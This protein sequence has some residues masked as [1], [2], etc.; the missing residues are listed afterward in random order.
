MVDH[1]LITEDF[2]FRLSLETSTSWENVTQLKNP[3]TF[4]TTLRK[5]VHCKSLSQQ[6]TSVL[7]VRSCESRSP[8]LLEHRNINF[9]WCNE[10]EAVCWLLPQCLS[11]PASFCSISPF[12]FRIL[13]PMVSL[14]LSFSCYGSL[15]WLVGMWIWLLTS[16]L[17]EHRV[18][19][20]W[21]L[22]GEARLV[23][24]VVKN[25]TC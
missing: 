1:T 16:F 25:Y 17:R 11:F 13:V 6:G 19:Y 7:L 23:F 14:P 20:G 12:C 2:Q 10:T 22:N 5:M 21:C 18:D 9:C 4:V 24:E 3:R 15:C 8:S